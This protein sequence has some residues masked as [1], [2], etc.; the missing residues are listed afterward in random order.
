MACH[1]HLVTVGINRSRS[2]RS[3]PPSHGRSLRTLWRGSPSIEC[4]RAIGIQLLKSN[5]EEKYVPLLIRAG[6]G[7]YSGIY[8]T[9]ST[10]FLGRKKA[11]YFTQKT[12]PP[13]GGVSEVRELMLI[14]LPQSLDRLFDRISDRTIINSFQAGNLAVT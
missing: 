6:K 10:S 7:I 4:I 9:F 3:F 8:L 12:T 5:E 11:R 2:V 13:Q 14:E 1:F